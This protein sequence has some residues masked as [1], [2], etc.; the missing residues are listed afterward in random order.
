[1]I[2]KFRTVYVRDSSC[3]IYKFLENRELIEKTRLPYK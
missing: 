2:N 3:Y 1:M